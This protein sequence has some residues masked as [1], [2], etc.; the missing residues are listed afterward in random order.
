M[1]LCTRLLILQSLRWLPSKTLPLHQWRLGRTPTLSKQSI[2]TVP[3][4]MIMPYDDLQLTIWFVEPAWVFTR[5][6][7]P[8]RH[9]S[10]HFFILAEFQVQWPVL[11]PFTVPCSLSLE[12]LPSCLFRL[13]SEKWSMIPD[14]IC[15]SSSYVI[16]HPL[17]NSHEVWDNSTNY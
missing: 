3:T 11:S 15:L 7:S 14:P 10:P 2:P 9:Y 8:Y 16:Y 4:L 17:L 12:G 1:P 5:L 13:F 6:C